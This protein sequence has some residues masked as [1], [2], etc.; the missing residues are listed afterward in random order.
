[1][2]GGQRWEGMKCVFTRVL[3]FNA[4]LNLNISCYTYTQCE[5]ILPVLKRLAETDVTHM[6]GGKLGKTRQ[7]CPES[8]SVR[9]THN[10]ICL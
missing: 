4:E 2:V 6:Y 8:N 10:P 1:M 7:L 3:E 9:P 5:N